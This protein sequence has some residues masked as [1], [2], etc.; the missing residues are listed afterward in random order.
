MKKRV[1][2]LLILVFAFAATFN[3]F[4]QRKVETTHLIVKSA[5]NAAVLGTDEIGRVI[6][7]DL[8]LSNVI[9]QDNIDSYVQNPNIL[10]NKNGGFYLDVPNSLGGYPGLNSLSLLTETSSNYTVS[11]ERNIGIGNHLRM[12]GLESISIGSVNVVLGSYCKVFGSNNYSSKS[13]QTIFGNGINSDN[14]NYTVFYGSYNQTTPLPVIGGQSA[15]YYPSVVIGAGVSG[16]SRLDGMYFFGSGRITVPN[17]TSDLIDT[18]ESIINLRYFNE[19]VPI[20]QA[21]TNVAIDNTD[22]AK[23]I[24]NV[25]GGINSTDLSYVASPSQGIVESSNGN[26][27]VIPLAN[28][29]NA[30]LMYA[31]FTEISTETVT[32]TM[33]AHQDNALN[34]SGAFALSDPNIKVDYT[35]TGRLKRMSFN[36]SI[37]YTSLEPTDKGDWIVKIPLTI[38]GSVGEGAKLP[39]IG[40]YSSPDTFDSAFNNNDAFS[41]KGYFSTNSGEIILKIKLN[42]SAIPSSGQSGVSSLHFNLVYRTDS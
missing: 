8:D 4:S 5:K 26:N 14:G 3:A 10:K 42:G 1:F 30:G 7:K 29:I 11:G 6:E 41:C 13:H 22:P 38:H 23:P 37:S 35:K 40:T 19:N 17:L 34:G 28:N 31:G 18:D 12:N 33:I 21:G 36:V 20:Y 15:E 27:A 9:T 24:I 2:N 39:L 32:A 16:S 25:S